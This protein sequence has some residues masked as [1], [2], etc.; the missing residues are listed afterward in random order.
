MK[1]GKIQRKRIQSKRDTK[2][3]PASVGRLSA[4]SILCRMIAPFASLLR[5]VARL[6]ATEGVFRSLFLLCFYSYRPPT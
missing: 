6:A 5:E 3:D 2:A 4:L 1:R